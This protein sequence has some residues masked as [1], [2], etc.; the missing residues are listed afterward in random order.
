MEFIYTSFSNSDWILRSP[1]VIESY[2]EF[3]QEMPYIVNLTSMSSLS[4]QASTALRTGPPWDS[5]GPLVLIRS[6]GC[7]VGVRIETRSYYSR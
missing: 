5:L 7:T 3:E 6:S 4:G 1:F 2:R